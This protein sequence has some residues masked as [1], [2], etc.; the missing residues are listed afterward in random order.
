MF[1]QNF[2]LTIY[3]DTDGCDYSVYVKL[4]VVIMIALVG[5]TLFMLN[6]LSL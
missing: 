4:P 2:V 6:Y 1:Y 3:K 5:I